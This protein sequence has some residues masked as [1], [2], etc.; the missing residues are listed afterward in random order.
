M[1][2]QARVLSLLGETSNVSKVGINA[3]GDGIWAPI[4]SVHCGTSGHA[5]KLPRSGFI[6]IEVEIAARLNQDITPAIAAGGAEA[7]LA[8]VECFHIGVE[9][10]ATRL[11]DRDAAG[12]LAQLADG[13]NTFGYVHS[14]IPFPRR[15]D[16]AGAMVEVFINDKII[17]REP[18]ASAFGSILN[19]IIACG[20]IE[21]RPFDGLKAGM[22]VT[23]GALSG[24]VPIQGPARFRAG[25]AGFDL[26]EFE[27]E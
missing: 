4:P 8:A 20:R 21:E 19:P 24:L 2:V 22:L 23:T 6:G 26:V 12:P 9:L 17:A 5:F 18:G 25:L 14:E 27:L 3:D 15:N 16:L 11:E 1:Q 10:V 13:I 7:V